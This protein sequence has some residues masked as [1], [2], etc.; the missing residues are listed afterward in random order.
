MSLQGA[1]VE[2]PPMEILDYGCCAI[3]MIGS[4]QSSYW[5]R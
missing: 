1:L 2:V 4:I 5:Q 3:V